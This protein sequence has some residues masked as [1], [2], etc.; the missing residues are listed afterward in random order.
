MKNPTKNKNRISRF[1]PMGKKAVTFETVIKKILWIIFFAV[2]FFAVVV[3]LRK[4]T[5]I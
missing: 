3:L 2:I 1:L 4:L 5:V